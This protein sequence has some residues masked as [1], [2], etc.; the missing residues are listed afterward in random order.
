[1]PN[2][3]KN[4]IK[5]K[6]KDDFDL[7]SKKYINI[8]KNNEKYFDFNKVI[9]MPK[10]LDVTSSSSGKL[11]L[12]YLQDPLNYIESNKNR[13]VL[14]EIIKKYNDETIKLNNKLSNN[15]IKSLLNKYS[16]EISE[17]FRNFDLELGKIYLNNIQ[18]YEYP[19]WYEWSNANWET[20]WNSC[21]TNI[22]ESEL[23]IAFE[24]AWSVPEPILLKL[25]DNDKNLIFDF[26]YADE[27]QC[28]YGKTIFQYNFEENEIKTTEIEFNLK[29]DDEDE[30]IDFC[31]YIFSEEI[32]EIDS[33]IKNQLIYKEIN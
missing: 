14:L 16:K 3:V 30:E 15:N 23:Y 27:G 21:E 9:P 1:M 31:E 12:E 8:T 24:T 33:M 18:K 4:I 10:E 22:N 7:V 29:E 25:I 17:E 11:A 5:F 13:G 32:D 20:K 26:Y 2:Y 19:T 28:F 6:N